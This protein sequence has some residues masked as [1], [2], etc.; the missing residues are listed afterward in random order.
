MLELASG[1]WEDSS[2]IQTHIKQTDT[3]LDICPVI[4]LYEQY[5]M[6]SVKLDERL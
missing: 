4:K 6:F 5:Y 3:Y 2:E 1:L